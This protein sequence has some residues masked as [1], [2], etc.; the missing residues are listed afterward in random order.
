M[1]ICSSTK[2]EKVLV[3]NGVADFSGKSLQEI[4]VE[5]TRL[6]IEEQIVHLNLSYNALKTIKSLRHLQNV[7]ILD[8]SFNQLTHLSDFC[9]ALLEL[10]YLTKLIL[11]SNKISLIGPHI[12]KL[13]TLTWLDLRQNSIESISSDLGLLTKLE[14]LDLSNNAL[15]ALPSISELRQLVTLDLSHNDFY[16]FPEDF[17]IGNENLRRLNL[18]Y[19]HL[20]CLPHNLPRLSAL[21]S[22]DASFNSITSLPNTMFDLT[23]LVDVNL[24]YNSI[25]HIPAHRLHRL[26]KLKVLD[27]RHNPVSVL[28][29][30]QD[31]EPVPQITQ[32]LEALELLEQELDSIFRPLSQRPQRRR[33]SFGCLYDHNRAV[34]F[35]IFRSGGL[36]PAVP[37]LPP[38][39]IR[40]SRRGSRVMP[41][42]PFRKVT[43]SPSVASFNRSPMSTSSTLNTV[44]PN[45]SYT[46]YTGQLLQGDTT[47]V[48]SSYPLSF[49]LPP[50]TL[51]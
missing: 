7:S 2:V 46:S 51:R 45:L 48:S 8:L 34:R 32:H 9:E 35:S 44:T 24:Y 21:H 19:N 22:L 50:C 25:F 23:E 43:A 36:P 40:T 4:P 16:T 15:S 6:A 1:G 3:S 5:L 47:P 38:E 18:S 12:A 11:V 28:F 30:V 49:P 14:Y 13:D 27:I 33:R 39:N 26:R 20:S 37:E 29:R 42:A 41:S 17:L 31:L 10:P